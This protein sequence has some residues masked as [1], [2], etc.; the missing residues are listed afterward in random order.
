MK[1][2]VITRHAIT[3]YGSLLQALA[4]QMIVEEIGCAC[5]IIDYVRNDESY[6]KHEKT[7][8]KRKTWNSNIIKRAIYIIIRQPES[9]LAG[10]RFERER[11][12][13]LKLSKLYCTRES[14]G[15]DYPKADV[16]MTGSDQ[17][18]GPTEDGSYDYNYC[19]SFAKDK[20]K[21]AFAASFGHKKVDGEIYE[22]FKK[23]LSSYARIAVR[24][25]SAVLLLKDMG[26]E[27]KQVLD[28]TLLFNKCFWNSYARTSKSNRGKK[29]ILVYQIHSNP[30]L[31]E[32]AKM[33]ARKKKLKLIRVSP[34]LHQISR[35]G[36]LVWCPSISDF[37]A[38]IRDAELL[39]TDSFHGTAFAINFNT[40]F[41]EI[42][43]SNGTDT[44]NVSIL[45]LTGLSDRVL[46]DNN[47]NI[48]DKT[49]DFTYANEVLAEKREESRKILKEMIIG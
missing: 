24:E 4:T 1:V 26:I 45:T 16:Y 38:Y 44:R 12:K 9:I 8:L 40:P 21:I 41:V 10:R 47:K 42:L 11:K 35:P 18:W 36:K 48:E 31:G 19:L 25:D 15:E 30:K 37:L 46:T 49:I 7:L 22:S 39:I 2:E 14:L 20:K 43:P 29:F 17:V 23:F 32:Y 33:V 13:Y 5:E 34:S 6:I 3:N 27:A 28:P